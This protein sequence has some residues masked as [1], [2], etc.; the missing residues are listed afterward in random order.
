MTDLAAVVLLSRLHAP[1]PHRAPLREI[2]AL[3]RGIQAPCEQLPRMMWP[4]CHQQR[5]WRVSFK[6]TLPIDMA[7][8]ASHSCSAPSGIIA[9]NCKKLIAGF[10]GSNED[11]KVSAKTSAGR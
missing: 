6:S 10:P 1:V 7:S 4:A 5:E 11:G 2:P 9:S 3:H 8:C